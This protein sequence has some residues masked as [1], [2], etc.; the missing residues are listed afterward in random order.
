MLCSLPTTTITLLDTIAQHL[1]GSGLP[2]TSIEGWLWLTPTSSHVASY[3]APLV[4]LFIVIVWT[5]SY[6][7]LH[8]PKTLRRRRDR[9]WDCGFGQE[10]NTRAQY[11]ATAFG[12]PIRR[13]FQP[14]WLIEE[15]IEQHK[16]ETL[17][18]TEIRYQLNIRDRSSP[19]LYEPIGHWIMFIA[20]HLSRI[21]TGN[22]RI[23][24]S[25]S[26]FT[27]LFLLWLITVT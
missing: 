5:L 25:Y 12:M 22:I 9:P 8:G 14:V 23:Y 26:F 2:K 15:H 21:Q 13:I 27:L 6:L 1:L 24:L 11:T 20:R 3:S 16:D 17:Y 18:N 4:L 7:L 10:G 19:I